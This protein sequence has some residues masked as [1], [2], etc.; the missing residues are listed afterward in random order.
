M[1]WGVNDVDLVVLPRTGGG[2]GSNRD[3]AL[4]LLLHPVHRGG[5]FVHFTDLVGDACVEQDALSRRGLTRVDVRHDA[6]VAHLG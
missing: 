3:S 2:G 1:T 5:T 6:D 4:L